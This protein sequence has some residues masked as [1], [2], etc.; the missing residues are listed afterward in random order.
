M[1]RSIVILL[2]ALA[3][4]VV[5]TGGHA[6]SGERLLKGPPP[7][8]APLMSIMVSD[9]GKAKCVQGCK[10]THRDEVKL[11]NTLYPPEHRIEDHRKCLD[12]ARTKFDACMATC[13]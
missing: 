11:C 7:A 4:C 2:G 1:A 8:V 12:K 3:V 10:D 6:A 13:R 5:A 9:N